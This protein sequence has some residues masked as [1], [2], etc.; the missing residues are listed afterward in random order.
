MCIQYILKY[1]YVCFLLTVTPP[2][3]LALSTS[4]QMDVMM[5]K[6]ATCRPFTEK[7]KISY[8]DRDLKGL[9]KTVKKEKK[10]STEV[11]KIV[12]VEKSKDETGKLVQKKKISMWNLILA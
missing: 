12:R 6:A 9:M 8:E 7:M 11:P 5:E 1:I 2:F 3:T 10:S 4:A